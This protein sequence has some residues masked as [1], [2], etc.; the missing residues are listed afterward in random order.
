M[1]LSIGIIKCRS[2]SKHKSEIK[3]E[4]RVKI[5][6]EIMVEIVVVTFLLVYKL[7]QA[8]KIKLHKIFMG[9]T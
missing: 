5:V 4:F 8:H 2:T 1:I 6:L 7:R 9:N 3:V